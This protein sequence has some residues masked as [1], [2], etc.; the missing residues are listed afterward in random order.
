MA[1]IHHSDNIALD[2]HT[3]QVPLLIMLSKDN[4]SGIPA[5][6]LELPEL[7]DSG[8]GWPSMEVVDELT[9]AGRRYVSE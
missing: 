2:E 5:L 4:A 3:G 1:S 9:C 8:L 7:C 6:L